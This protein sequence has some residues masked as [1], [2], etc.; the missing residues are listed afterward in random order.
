MK[1]LNVTGLTS[2]EAFRRLKEF[3]P[4]EI[5]PS[6]FET[7]LSEL[8]KI[9]LDPMG[10]MLLALGLL[11]LLIGNRTDALILFGAYIPV[12]GVDVLLQLKASK[13]LK[14]LGSSIQSTVKVIRD[15]RVQEVFSKTIVVGDIILFEEGQSL[16][17]DGVVIE[18]DNLRINE[19][20]LTGESVPVDKTEGV[21]FFAGTIPIQGRGLGEIGNTGKGTRFGKIASLLE[22]TKSQS[23]PLQ[24]KV[25]TLIHRFLK[26]ALGLAFL[27][28]GLQVLRGNGW[29]QSLI[30]AVTFG[31]AAIP[32]EFPL[33][34]TLYLS[35]GAWRLARHGV[36]IK[37]LPSV[38]ALGSV[39]VICT[40]K[41]GTLTEG[42]FQLESLVP[43]SE[44]S[45]ELLWK[46]ALMACE[47]K[48]VDSMEAA[49]Y[50]KG[51]EYHSLLKDWHLQYDY[52]FETFGKHMSHVWRNE[53]G[54]QIISM[55]GAIEGVLEHCEVTA[56][57]E[58]AIL[59][60]TQSLARQGKRLL[61]LAYREGTSSGDRNHDERG[62][63]F[64]GVLAFNDPTRQ[65]A[66]SAVLECQKTG[67][68]IKMLTGDHPETAH[69]VADELG[70]VH[71]HALLFT[72]DQLSKMDKLK[73]WEAFQRGAVFSRVL[74][75]QKHEMVQALKAS[76]KTVAMTGDGINDAP[77]LRLADVGISMGLNATDVARSTAHMI[78]LKNDFRG[79]VE[80]VF[81]GRR[82]FENL[83]KS[84]SYLIAF[85]VPIILLAFA[86]PL[87]GWGDLLLPI[88]IVL[89][90]LIVHPV[91]AFAFENLPVSSSKKGKVLLSAHQT[92]ES[93]VAGTFLSVIALVL[94]RTF[95]RE[96]ALFTTLFGVTGFMLVEVL[97]KVNLRILMVFLTLVGLTQL[98]ARS[99]FLGEPFHLNQ[100]GFKEL[101]WTF[102]LGM[103]SSLYSL[104]RKKWSDSREE[105]PDPRYG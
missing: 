71:D 83:Q 35:L 75:E 79:I 47:V 8:K 26:V 91:S 78:L 49:I 33:V 86:P 65:S 22:E 21:S 61:G 59:N 69:A 2:Q 66:K 92:I 93:L 31:M 48:I 13:A 3:G 37:S 53:N 9:F 104:I 30:V 54:N 50:E 20:A 51:Q 77:A 98:L 32:E 6:R 11:Y 34:F 17:A 100:I 29:V 105:G 41:T 18:S 63:T 102:L 25:N 1:N 28:F 70:I 82:I 68:E 58:T 23:T 40:D 7:F 76:G 55:K 101:A 64:L 39:D 14:A 56:S 85:H 44:R 38:E 10:L 57:E 88:H 87:L 15:G 80:A 42:R 46:C 94:Y 19:A 72:G 89:L 84:F 5:I 36:L 4:N 27:L 24:T 73:R 43:L 12:T 96:V 103:G 67:I 95:G 16:P 90:E 62:L 81:E 45:N 60:L 97:P 74:P 52:P 99:P